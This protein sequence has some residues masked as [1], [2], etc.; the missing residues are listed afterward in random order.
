MYNISPYMYEEK[1]IWTEIPKYMGSG[2]MSDF[3]FLKFPPHFFQ[4]PTISIY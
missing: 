4:F 1:I 3:S 2:I